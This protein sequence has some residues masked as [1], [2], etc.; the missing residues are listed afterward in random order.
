MSLFDRGGLQA[1]TWLRAEPTTSAGASHL[2]VPLDALPA[3]L[4]QRAPGQKIGI[5]IANTIRP[6]DIAAQLPQLALIAIAFPLHSD[7]R[8]FSLARALR[9]QGFKGTLRAVGRL[10]PDQFAYALACGFDEIELADINATRQPVSQWQKA[11]TRITGVY[12]RGY[13]GPANILDQRRA[14]REGQKHG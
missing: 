1:E 6:K 4:A 3:A 10:I 11:A 2:L 8:G 13:A 12:Q 14:A 9:R 5:E 7:G